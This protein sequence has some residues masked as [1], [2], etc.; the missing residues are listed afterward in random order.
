MRQDKTWR[1]STIRVLLAAGLILLLPL[2]AMRFSEEVAWDPADFAV[3]GG[4]LVGTGLLYE[5]AARRSGSVAYRA[6][7]GV[8]LAAAFLLVWLN[9]AVGIIG[10]EDNPANAMYIGVLAV[11]VVGALLAR[12]RPRGMARA[13]IPLLACHLHRLGYRWVA[14]T[15]TRALR[16][17]FHRL[18]LRPLRLTRADPARLP[19][20]GASWGTYYDHDPVVMAGKISHGLYAG[21]RA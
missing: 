4:L 13:L 6:A 8:A 14:F 20:G 19:D 2:V 9:L 3:A 17:T 21:E 1:R 15:A 16:N 12:F 10:D 5:A 11:G 7:A 18:G